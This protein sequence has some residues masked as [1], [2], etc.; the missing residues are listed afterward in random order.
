MHLS[1]TALVAIVIFIAST[2]FAGPSNITDDD[3]SAA[4]AEGPDFPPN[5]TT[6]SDESPFSN[7]SSPITTF[8]SNT[9]NDAPKDIWQAGHKLVS[10]P[11]GNYEVLVRNSHPSFT[12]SD[13]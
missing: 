7:S 8:A 11:G 4:L 6:L 9:T 13:S 1:K 2:S 10:T 3:V 12:T 5:I